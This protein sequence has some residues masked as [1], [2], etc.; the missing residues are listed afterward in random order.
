MVASRYGKIIATLVAKKDTSA[1]T[2]SSI[3]EKLVKIQYAIPLACFGTKLA[4]KVKIN[5]HEYI[6]P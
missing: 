3:F 6:C 5:F 1:P 4:Q 2:N